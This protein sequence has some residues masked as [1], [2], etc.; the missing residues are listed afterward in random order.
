LQRE[1]PTT[2]YNEWRQTR[3]FDD[4]EEGSEAEALLQEI[5]LNIAASKQG[6]IDGHWSRHERLHGRLN[7]AFP[8]S[9]W[10]KAVRDGLRDFPARIPP[11]HKPR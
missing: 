4:S 11:Q 1:A 7:T 5:T 6:K 10:A 3:P 2:D 9:P 8:N